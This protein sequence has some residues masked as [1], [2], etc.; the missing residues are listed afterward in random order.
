MESKAQT[1]HPFPASRAQTMH[2]FPASLLQPFP[3][4]RAQT[5][6]PFPVSGGCQ[7]CVFHLL[8]LQGARNICRKEAR[9]DRCHEP[10]EKTEY[11][12]ISKSG[13]QRRREKL[14][15]KMQKAAESQGTNEPIA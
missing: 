3:A 15:A 14:K 5:R 10:H 2:L 8:Y 4:S 13:A 1:M 9:C 6:N 11:T 12:K 7:P